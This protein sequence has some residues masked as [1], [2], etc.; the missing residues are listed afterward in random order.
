M[1]VQTN[2]VKSDI[3]QWYPS[4]ILDKNGGDKKFC[5]I[6]LNQPIVH[7]EAFDRLWSNASYKFFADGGANRVFDTFKHDKALL[8]RYTPTEIRGDLDSLRP[9]VRE[10]YESKNIKITRVTC[11]DTT[12]FQKCVALMHEKEEKDGQIYDLVAVP[13]LGGR[14]DQTISN[15]NMLFQLRD[16]TDRRVILI[17]DENLTMLLD[18]G[19]HH[20]HCQLDLEGPTC[21]ILPMGTSVTLTTKGL[22]W[23]MDQL[24]CSFGGIIS[25]SNSVVNDLVEVTADAPAVWTIELN[26][27]K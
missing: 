24:Y 22:K 17:S 23:D 14:F 2:G 4:R 9:E 11:Q 1:S 25:S 12:D 18:K 27:P 7:L 3:K 16:D 10:Y 6:V 20:I 15:I 19:T 26:L 5:L 13:A 21:G 8:E